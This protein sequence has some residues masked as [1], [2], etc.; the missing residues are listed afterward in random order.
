[1]VVPLIREISSKRRV[2][3][4]VCMYVCGVPAVMNWC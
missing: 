2:C 4:R 3:V 1:M